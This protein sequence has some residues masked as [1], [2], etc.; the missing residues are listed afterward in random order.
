MNK[1]LLS[2]ALCCGIGAAAQYTVTGRI[3]DEL[4]SSPLQHV[5]VGIQNTGTVTTTDINGTFELT[6]AEKN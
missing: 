1:I 4:T 6:S 2:A 5:V 3:T